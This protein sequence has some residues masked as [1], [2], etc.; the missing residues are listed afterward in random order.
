MHGIRELVHAIAGLEGRGAG[1]HTDK[2]AKERVQASGEADS[3]GLLHRCRH[4]NTIIQPNVQYT[5]NPLA[6]KG[7]SERAL[8]ARTHRTVA[9]IFRP[10]GHD[11]LAWID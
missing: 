3:S 2:S 1:Q 8:S 5:N 7:G 11:T 10:E 4:N 9:F 6:T